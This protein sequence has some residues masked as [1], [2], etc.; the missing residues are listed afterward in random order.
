[1]VAQIQL[2]YLVLTSGTNT[3][4]QYDIELVQLCNTVYSQYNN[5]ISYRLVQYVDVVLSMPGQY[6]IVIQ[7]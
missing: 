1:M 4:M 7:Y 3:V 5:A 6:S 2:Y